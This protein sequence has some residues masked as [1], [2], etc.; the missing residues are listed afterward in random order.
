MTETKPVKKGPSVALII[1][2]IILGVIVLIG[3]INCVACGKCA[4]E[5]SKQ[6]AGTENKGKVGEVVKAGDVEWKVIS[7]KK[8][9]TLKDTT[10]LYGPKKASGVFVIV[11]LQV[12]NTGKE[13]KTADSSAVVLI[14]DKGREFSASTDTIFYI[15][16]D[17]DLFLEQLNP[18]TSKQRMVVFDVDK[19]AKGLKFRGGDLDVLSENNALIDLGI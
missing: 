1:I 11:T 12:K 5:V 7:V 8:Q 10:G 14:D 4:S 9:A 13:A 6:V 15:P 18:N 3:V 16:Q 19:K 17:K 2:L